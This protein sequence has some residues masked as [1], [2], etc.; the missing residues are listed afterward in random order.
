MAH[1][2][3]TFANGADLAEALASRVA[4]QLAEGV[5]ARGEASI[6]VSGG[7]TP[8]AFFKA[9]SVKDIA[10]SKVVITLVDER[11]VPPESDRSNHALV[12]SLLLQ[13]K[14][15]AAKFVPLYHAVADAEDAAFL[16]SG[17]VKRISQ[18]FDVVILGMGG[19]GH[20]ASFF[21]GGNNLERALSAKGPRS[22]ITMEA[23]G[24]GEPRLTFTFPALQDAR[25]LILHIEGEAKKPVIETALAQGAAGP[26]PIARVIA[27][28]STDTEIYWAP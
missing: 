2:F 5:A 13:N 3:N 28:A 16:T 24:A 19:D 7:S 23:P 17:D 10:W 9:L 22:V 20:T 21:P 12:S 14:A 8:K 6:A 26:L 11:F 27:N 1:H 25:L 4:A 18:P 15:A